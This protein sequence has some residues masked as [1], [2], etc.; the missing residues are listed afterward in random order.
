MP[1]AT[2]KLPACAI[3]KSCYSSENNIYPHPF[4]TARK[5]VH[6]CILHWQSFLDQFLFGG[7]MTKPVE[8]WVHTLST[9][10]GCLSTG[11][12]S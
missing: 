4:E 12:H 6:K 8:R 1:L 2:G 3:E 10:L 7:C 5:A 11:S 9:A